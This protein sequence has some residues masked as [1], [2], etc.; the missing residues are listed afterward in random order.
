MLQ[1]LKIVEPPVPNY[2]NVEY[3][4][5]RSLGDPD[6]AVRH[7]VDRLAENCA[8]LDGLTDVKIPSSA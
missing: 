6:T 2:S 8:E 4:Q 5:K 1:N 3:L 7:A